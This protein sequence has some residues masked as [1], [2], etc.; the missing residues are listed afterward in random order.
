MSP[1]RRPP[2]AVVLIC[3]LLLTV[4]PIQASGGV[5]VVLNGNTLFSD[6][7]AVLQN[8]TTY[9]PLRAFA[10]TFAQ[11]EVTWNASQGRAV[12][13]TKGLTLDVQV[14]R[15]Y[16]VANDRYFYMADSILVRDG[17]VLVP[18]RALSKAYGIDV[19][20]NAAN[21][22]VY[23][24]GSGKPAQSGASFYDADS[25]LWLARIIHAESQGERL[26]GKMAV[27]NV[28]LN[29]V[30]SPSFP[31]T[32]YGV[33][34]DQNNGAQFTPTVNGTIYNTPG[35]ES[36]IAAKMCLEGYT[37]VPDRCLYFLNPAIAV[38]SWITQNR[39]YI[40]AIGNH[41]FYA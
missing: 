30:K 26:K 36:V 1:K 25:V 14:G 21:R 37:V 27:G 41:H 23:L 38:S 28:V 33:I 13:R 24:T 29:R 6:V 17:R 3:V 40:T 35:A 19:A 4:A 10:E 18:V 7:S 34:F 39:H 8:G 32:I 5:K 2:L 15:Q 20:W 12:V 11:S 9:V 31:N 16:M 22:T